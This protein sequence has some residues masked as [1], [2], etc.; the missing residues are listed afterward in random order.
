MSKIP[1]VF[2]SMLNVKILVRGQPLHTKEIFIDNPPRFILLYNTIHKIVYLY[3]YLGVFEGIH[4][5]TGYFDIAGEFGH[6]KT[7]PIDKYESSDLPSVR[8]E[9]RANF[10]S[11][12]KDRSVG[13][14]FYGMYF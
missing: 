8:D 2:R 7:R 1:A 9:W 11:V 5:T 4:P 3:E 10:V 14:V 6:I 12:F 13:G